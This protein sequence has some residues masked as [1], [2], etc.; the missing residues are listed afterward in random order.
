M[1]I[2]LIVVGFILLQ[3]GARTHIASGGNQQLGGGLITLVMQVGGIGLMIY[4]LVKLF[5]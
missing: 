2:L 3:V 1:S 4:G 5:S